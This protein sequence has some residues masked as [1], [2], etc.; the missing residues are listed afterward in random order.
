MLNEVFSNELTKGTTM[1]LTEIKKMS[2]KERLQTMEALWD[3]IL[4][5]ESEIKSPEW[6]Q[7]ILE[8]RIKSIESGQ[9]EL[10]S[11]EE[12]KANRKL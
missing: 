9:A 11:F 10:I 1:T 8:G 2:L 7:D 6:H 5:E 12:L 4:D 3:S